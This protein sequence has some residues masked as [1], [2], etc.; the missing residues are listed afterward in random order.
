MER[1]WLRGL[2]DCDCVVDVYGFFTSTQCLYSTFKDTQCL[3]GF[4]TDILMFVPVTDAPVLVRL[5]YRHVN[6]CLQVR[7]AWQFL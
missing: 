4:F 3:Y 6:A 5:L 7:S 1:R 2:A